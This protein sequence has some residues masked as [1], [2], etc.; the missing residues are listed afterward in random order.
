MADKDSRFLMFKSFNAE[1][2]WNAAFQAL[3]QMAAVKTL[4]QV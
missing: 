4:N 1:G 2:R 3:S